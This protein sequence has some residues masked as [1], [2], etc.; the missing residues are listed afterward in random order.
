MGPVARMRALRCVWAGAAALALASCGS[1]NAATQ[2]S[3][4][5]VAT[6]TTPARTA[7]SGGNGFELSLVSDRGGRPTPVAAAT[8]F[9]R[10]GG[11]HGIPR[12]GWRLTN[13][14]QDGATL[15]SHR[16]VLHA[17]RGND[18]TW[19]VDSGSTCTSG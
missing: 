17:V 3:Q 18:G 13:Q 1:E 14:N 9:A 19:Q 16:A 7:C 11:V 6:R 12:G 10:H 8:W 5:T 2:P 4:T 15:T